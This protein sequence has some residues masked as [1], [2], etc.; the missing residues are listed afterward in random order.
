MNNPFKFYD[1]KDEV[2]ENRRVTREIKKEWDLFTQ[3]IRSIINNAEGIGA[4]DTQSREELYAYF[5]KQ[6][7]N[8][9]FI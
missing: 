5:E 2:K 9:N 7:K 4:T 6:L 3:K 1:G 8:G